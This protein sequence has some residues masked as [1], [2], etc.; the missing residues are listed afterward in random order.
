MDPLSVAASIIAVL[1]LSH[2]VVQCLN[3]IRDAPKECQQCAIEVSNLLG[4]LVSLRYRA[5]QACSGDPWFEQ[6]RQLNVENGP[7]DQYREAL[8]LLRLE[9]EVGQGMQK[10]TRQLLWKYRKDEVQSILTRVER[11]KSLV[12]IALE[13]DHL[14]V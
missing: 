12:N 11:L 4:P 14:Y 5:G 10:V 9:T 3:G 13:M 7:L 1:Q 2:E 6:L 8:D